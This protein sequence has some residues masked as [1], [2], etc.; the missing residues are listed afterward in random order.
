M[1]LVKYVSVWKW[2]IV[3]VTQ[4]AM[5]TEKLYHPSKHCLL[6]SMYLWWDTTLVYN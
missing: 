1:L 2:T 6:S 4:S 3:Q 5:L